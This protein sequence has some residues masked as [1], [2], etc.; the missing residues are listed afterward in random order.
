MTLE[1]IVRKKTRK[2]YR[3]TFVMRDYVFLKHFCFCAP[4]LTVG[5][6]PLLQLSRNRESANVKVLYFVGSDQRCGTKFSACSAY[7]WQKKEK[8]ILPGHSSGAFFKKNNVRLRTESI[9]QCVFLR[10][11]TCCFRVYPMGLTTITQWGDAILSLSESCLLSRP[12]RL[13]Y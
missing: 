9:L 7:W 11:S 4:C 12:S 5:A 10:F 8:T 3:R 1:G 13:C 2:F 6:V